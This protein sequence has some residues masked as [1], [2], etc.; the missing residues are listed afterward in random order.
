VTALPP[1]PAGDAAEAAARTRSAAPS[2]RGPILVA[3]ALAAL[4]L[5]AWRL[6]SRS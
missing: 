5:A 3:A 2:R 6:R 4:A 1:G